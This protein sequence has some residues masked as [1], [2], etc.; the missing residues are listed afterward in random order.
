MLDVVLIA[1]NPVCTLYY[2]DPR[3]P[4]AEVGAIPPLSIEGKD[5]P[6]Q[7]QFPIYRTCPPQYGVFTYDSTYS[8]ASLEGVDHIQSC[9]D[10]GYCIGLL[11]QYTTYSTTVGQFRYDK[12][13]SDFCKPHSIV[14]VQEQHS[15]GSR[16]RIKPFDEQSITD[17]IKNEHLR[18]TEGILVWWY[19]RGWSTVTV[20]SREVSH[21]MH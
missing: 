17:E 16:V 6:A 12:E 13:I 8:E 18:L 15:L 21:S 4:F 9:E 10:A 7:P 19:G 14:L 20:E 11:L 2:N 1:C 3:M 5:Y